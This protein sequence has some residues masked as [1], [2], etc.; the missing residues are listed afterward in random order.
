MLSRSNVLCRSVATLQMNKK[1]LAK[2]EQ[3]LSNRWGLY[4]TGYNETKDL[5]DRGI[6]WDVERYHWWASDMELNE[7]S[8]NITNPSDKMVK[9]KLLI[10]G[11]HLFCKGITAQNL[12]SEAKKQQFDALTDAQREQYIQMAIRVREQRTAASN[13]AP[14]PRFKT[15]QTLLTEKSHASDDWDL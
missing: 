14:V 12:S 9:T 13:K 5:K 7:L 2:V 4:Y 15:H 11:F 10:E 1:G 8:M 6:A 3:S